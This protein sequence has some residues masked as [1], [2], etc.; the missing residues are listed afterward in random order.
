LLRNPISGWMGQHN[1]FDFTI[2]YTAEPGLRHFLT[3]T[4][5]VLSLAMIE[6]GVDLLIEAGIDAL[7][8]KSVQQSEYLITLWEKML[9]PL[10]YMLKSPRHA[11]QRGSHVSLGHAEGWRINQA[12]IHDLN[13][14][15]DFRAPDNIRLG[16]A[17]L[18]TTFADLQAAA[19]RLRRAV[20]EKMYARHSDQRSVIT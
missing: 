16:I 17:P 20:A 3:G 19:E 13:V 18:Y 7:R 12:L 9:A 6:P 1:P 11:E 2:E 8:A 14:L 4:P 15:P 5:P 10:G